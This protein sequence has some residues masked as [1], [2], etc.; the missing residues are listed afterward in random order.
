MTYV[1]PTQQLLVEVPAALEGSNLN[2]PFM[3]DVLSAM[4]AHERGGAALYRTVAARSNNPM[5][6]RQYKNFGQETVEHVEILETL[7]ANAGGDPMYVSPAARATER[8]G[9]SLIETTFMCS[10]SIDLMT[11]ELVMLEAVLLAEAK[12]HSNWSTLAQLVPKLPDAIRT[13]FAEATQR[14]E[15]QEDEHLGWA[16][17]TRSKMLSLQIQSGTVQKAGMAAEQMMAKIKSLFD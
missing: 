17:E 7:I 16:K 13:P 1:D 11:A 9:N 5:L 14:V 8:A 2:V 10:G 4:L 15:Q 12:D 6:Q 3:M